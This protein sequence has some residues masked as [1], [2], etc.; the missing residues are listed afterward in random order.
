MTSFMLTL[1]E[2]KV[3]DSVK[4]TKTWATNMKSL[5]MLETG[6]PRHFVVSVVTL[7]F[8]SCNIAIAEERAEEFQPI[9]V[10]IEEQAKAFTLPEVAKAV[11]GSY[12]VGETQITVELDNE[13]IKF[14]A[15]TGSVERVQWVSE[16]DEYGRFVYNE[17]KKRFER[18][19]HSVRVVMNDYEKIED[20][21][22]E[23]EAKSGKAFPELGFAIV[24]L[25]KEVHPL[26]FS[27]Q[28]E[29]RE[30]VKSATIEV[31]SPRQIPL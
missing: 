6:R 18:L 20:L 27:K 13:N 26:K 30:D 14:T 12:R 24:N 22:E 15:T 4:P 9:E 2:S 1:R 23:T 5:S 31:E 19:T 3:F 28:V 7:C 8:L 17:D 21:I 25:P 29:N 11:P 16:T 10:R